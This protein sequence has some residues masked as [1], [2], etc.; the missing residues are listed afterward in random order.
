MMS[1]TGTTLGTAPGAVRGLTFHK[2]IINLEI[3]KNHNY[4]VKG[5]TSHN[6][7]LT[8]GVAL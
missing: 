7:C 2:A 1:V 8:Y 6:A 5:Q 3:C 4:F